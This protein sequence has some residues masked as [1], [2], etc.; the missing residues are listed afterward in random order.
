MGLRRLCAVRAA[1]LVAAAC[2]AGMSPAAA[3]PKVERELSRTAHGFGRIA[4]PARAG[5]Y[6]HYFELRHGDCGRAPGWSDCATNRS[7]TEVS[8]PDIRFAPGSVAWIGYSIFV[9]RSFRPS[10]P[11]VSTAG[12]ITSRGVEL[13]KFL[14]VVY[15]NLD[16]HGYTACIV[17]SQPT[18]Q[19]SEDCIHAHVASLD[20]MKGRWTDIQI[21][22]DTR[23]PGGRIEIW[24]NDRLVELACRS[25]ARCRR[26]SCSSTRCDSGR[27]GPRCGSTRRLPSIERRRRTAGPAAP[28]RGRWTGTITVAVAGTAPARPAGP[29]DRVPVVHATVPAVVSMPRECVL[30]AGG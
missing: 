9:P 8:R 24:A 25:P 30:F 12:Q 16:R 29:P 15:M 11:V 26:R 7:R 22:F 13:R 27:A 4:E 2:L 14:P 28:R 21:G 18:R 5:A 23:V 10:D 1:V 6:A 20:R 3:D 17:R 19:E